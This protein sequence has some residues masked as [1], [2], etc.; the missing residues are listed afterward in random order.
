MSRTGLLRCDNQLPVNGVAALRA[1]REHVP[2]GHRD[3]F[4][5][6]ACALVDAGDLVA[7]A[8][9]LHGCAPSVRCSLNLRSEPGSNAGGGTPGTGS[10]G[11]PMLRDCSPELSLLVDKDGCAASSVRHSGPA[12]PSQA[13]PGSFCSTTPCRRIRLTDGVSRQRSCGHLP[14]V[15][16]RHREGRC[17][18]RSLRTPAR[19]GVI[20]TRVSARRSWECASTPMSLRHSG[21]LQLAK[22]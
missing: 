16:R 11:A 14:T 17:Q 20:R 10:T 1:V 18:A 6:L 8:C 15:G 7:L 12:T 19:H 9:V 13:W 3:A 21:P 22:V 2:V 4:P 5:V